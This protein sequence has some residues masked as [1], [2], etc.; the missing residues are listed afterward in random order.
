MAFFGLSMLEPI[1]PPPKKLVSGGQGVGGGAIFSTFWRQKARKSQKWGRTYG[2]FW[3]EYVRT[4]PP[5]PKKLVSRCQGGGGGLFLALY[6]WY[7][8]P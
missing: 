2:I 6:D 4:D 7:G 5:P 1:P 8:T 3:P